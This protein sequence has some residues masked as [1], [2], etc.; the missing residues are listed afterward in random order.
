MCILYVTKPLAATDTP[1]VIWLFIVNM[2]KYNNIQFCAGRN[3]APDVCGYNEGDFTGIE[4]HVE[5]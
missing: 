3:R 4:M 1:E 5:K 2:T